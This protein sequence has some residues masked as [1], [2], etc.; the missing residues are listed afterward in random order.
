MCVK[1]FECKQNKQ[2][3]KNRSR[4]PNMRFRSPGRKFKSLDC[5]KHI[6]TIENVVLAVGNSV[7]IV[8]SRLPPGGVSYLLDPKLL[9]LSLIKVIYYNYTPLVYLN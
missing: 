2:F 4:L 1:S 3:Y 6:L 8:S 7:K 9:K 5:L